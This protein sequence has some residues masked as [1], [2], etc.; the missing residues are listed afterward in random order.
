MKPVPILMLL[1]A[2][3]VVTACDDWNAAGRPR[4]EAPQET[5]LAPCSRPEAHLG[6]RDWEI[7]AGRIG[8]ALIE[9]GAK[10][11]ALAEW[12]REVAAKLEGE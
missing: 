11:E 5:T 6:T 10:Q 1:V 7:I 8:D 4:L 12:A 3:Q 2:S 9:C